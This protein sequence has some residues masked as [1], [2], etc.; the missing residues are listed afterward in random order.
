MAGSILVC[1]NTNLDNRIVPVQRKCDI[2][3][4]EYEKY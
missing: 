3:G 2:L 4:A 1:Y